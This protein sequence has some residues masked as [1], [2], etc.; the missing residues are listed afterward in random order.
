MQAVLLP[1]HRGAGGVRRKRRDLFPPFSGSRKEGRS[2]Q[3]ERS[4]VG[5]ANGPTL[6]SFA[7]VPQAP[8]GFRYGTWLRAGRDRREP[9]PA[10]ASSNKKAAPPR[11][12]TDLIPAGQAARGSD[13]RAH[14]PASG[15]QVQLQT[16]LVHVCNPPDRT[17]GRRCFGRYLRSGKVYTTGRRRQPF[18]QPTSR[19]APPACPLESRRTPAAGPALRRGRRGLTGRQEP[20]ETT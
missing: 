6:L 9:D 3:A 2:E 17:S 11:R 19:S 15:G 12:R 14:L 5:P 1:F 18:F 8:P 13:P 20:E 4:G 7:Q 10:P 16:T